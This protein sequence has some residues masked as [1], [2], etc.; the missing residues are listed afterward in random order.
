M[1][2]I[3]RKL[4]NSKLAL[5]WCHSLHSYN[6]SAH[7]RVYAYICTG[8]LAHVCTQAMKVQHQPPCY[9]ILH[10]CLSICL[11]SIY[12]F[13]RTRPLISATVAGQWAQETCLLCPFPFQNY[14]TGVTEFT[15]IPPRF[16]QGCWGFELR[17]SGLYNTL[18]TEPIPQSHMQHFT[19]SQ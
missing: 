19:H 1:K 14:C 7:W 13:I 11:A 9:F 2:R 10:F 8:I 12:L 18:P 4:G 3:G 6:S 15:A 17:S 16:L 5:V